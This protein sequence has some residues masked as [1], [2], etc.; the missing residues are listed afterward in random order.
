[1]T[2]LPEPDRLD[3]AP[4]PRD[5]QQLFGQSNPQTDVLDSFNSGRLHH[6]WMITG[7]Q[8]IGKATLAYRIAAFLLASDPPDQGGMFDPVVPTSLDV[9][10]DHPVKHRIKT[11]TEPGLFVLKRPLDDKQEK[12]KTVIT[13]DEVRKLKGFFSLSAGGNGRRV[14]IVDALD[15]MNPQA[16][17]ALLKV[18]EEPPELATILLITHQPSRVLPTIRSRCRVLKCDP[19]GPDDLQAAFA[20]AAPD[21]SFDPGLAAL[22]DGSVGRALTLATGQGYQL[23]QD[24]VQLCNTLPKFDRSAAIQF[25]NKTTPPR[26][27]VAASDVVDLVDLFLSRMARSVLS[28]GG[29]I[30][31]AKGERDLFARLCPTAHAAR[32]WADCQHSQSQ[33]ARQ[34][35]QVNLDPSAVILDMLFHIE[36]TA[37]QTLRS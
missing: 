33:K 6:A 27:A 10:G 30:Q 3:H 23:Y 29:D 35:L 32:K 28:G 17:N 13:V 11:Q 8:G 7:P 26:P 25:A 21:H 22:A 34:A 31:A 37:Q 1:M 36:A 2:D 18:L 9:A 16:A 24:I 15:E 5:T 4:H 14:V 20:Q 19:L 12:L